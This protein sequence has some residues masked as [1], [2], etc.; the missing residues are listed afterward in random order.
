MNVGCQSFPQYVTVDADIE[1]NGPATVTW[2]WETSEGETIDK[3]ALAYYEF[4][5]QSVFIHYKINAAKDY[6]IQI[7][8]LAPNDITGRATFKAT[9]TP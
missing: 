9:C 5:S 1:T 7:H 6:W 3:D 2:R 8:I 4:G